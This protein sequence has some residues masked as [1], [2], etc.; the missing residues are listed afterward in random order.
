MEPDLD[1][2]AD[3]VEHRDEGRL[4]HLD[5]TTCLGLVGD[6]HVGRVAICADGGPVVFPVNYVLDGG[7][8]VFRTAP[9]SKLAAADQ[10]L[11]VAFQVDHVDVPRRMGWSVLVRGRLV[12]TDDPGDLERLRELP[13]DPFVGG[14]REHYV[15]VM[16]A[17]IT[18]R[19]IPIPDHVPEEWLHRPDGNVWL[20]RDGDD[21][22][23]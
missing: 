23:G 11:D 1:A 6:Q 22:L 2:Y 12:E 4:H 21:L 16:P 13:L 14:D 18:G 9:G 7:A 10:H 5:V 20:G 17:S 3:L 19:R 15:R 8:I